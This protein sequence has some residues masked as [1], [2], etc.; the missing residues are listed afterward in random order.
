MI[1]IIIADDHAVIREALRGLLV[2]SSDREICGEA[3]NGREAVELAK[4]L[5]PDVAVLDLSM[6]ELNGLEATMQVRRSLPNTEVLIL[7]V[8][9]DEDLVQRAMLA[10]ARGYL[11][12]SNAMMHFGPAIDALAHHKSYFDPA[13]SD[14]ML[15]TVASR[16]GGEVDLGGEPL[17]PRERE[18]VHLLA[19]GRSNKEVCRLLDLTVATVQTHRA[20]IMR[21]LKVNSIAGL[22]RYAVR[23]RIVDP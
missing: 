2:G 23:N 17:T 22:V 7:S 9:G 20:T 8:H 21:K 19:E 5:R 15:K 14:L 10:G 18:I 16:S 13:I 4:R 1:R 3:S 6:P 11:L 12:K